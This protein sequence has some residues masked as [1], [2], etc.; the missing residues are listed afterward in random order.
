LVAVFF[1]LSACS[2]TPAL[3]GQDIEV[4]NAEMVEAGDSQEGNI[5]A[6]GEL[7]FSEGLSSTSNYRNIGQVVLVFT[8]KNNDGDNVQSINV[9]PGEGYSMRDDIYS[10]SFL[11]DGASAEAVPTDEWVK[12]NIKGDLPE[13]VLEEATDIKLDTVTGRYQ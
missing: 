13:P 4:R 7:T 9:A 10:M 11:Q 5:M 2:G 1:S 3:I 6:R 8:L 12:F